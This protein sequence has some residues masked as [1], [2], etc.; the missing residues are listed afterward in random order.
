MTAP[1]LFLVAA[2]RAGSTQLAHWLASHPDIA[3]SPVKEP[4]HFA[5]HDFPEAYVR[6]THLND[7]DPARYRPGRPAQFA[8]FRERADYLR[9]FSGM[10]QRW[11]C[12]AS[13]SYLACP[14]APAAIRAAFPDARVL[15]LTRAPLD[16]ALSHYGLA[17]RTGRTRA[18]LGSELD[19]ELAGRTPLPARFLLRPSRQAPG[20]ARV[21]AEFGTAHLPLRF[22]DMVADPRATLERIA[23]F[24]DLDPRGFD[25]GAGARNAAASPRLPAL[26]ALLHRSGAKTWLRRHLPAA[27]KP[28]LRAAWFHDAPPHVSP[29]EMARL[30]RA[31]EATE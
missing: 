3:L 30:A 18:P 7:V 25:P 26:N 19:D 22:E 28:A 13:T 23:R 15:T 11:R 2:P 5:A 8:V 21:A 14:E 1:N 31:L 20:V 12:D 16:R 9:L 10:T 27:L 4:T 17:R 6:A 29:A 24:L